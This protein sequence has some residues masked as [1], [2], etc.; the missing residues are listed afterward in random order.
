[1]KQTRYAALILAAFFIPTTLSAHYI[2]LEQ[3]GK[4]AQVYFGEIQ[5]GEREKSPGKLDKMEGVKLFR[6]TAKGE[7][8]EIPLQ[9]KSQYFAGNVAKNSLTIAVNDSV[10]V[11]DLTKYGIGVVKP[12]YYARHGVQNSATAFSPTLTLDIMP[13]AKEKNT[14]QLFFNK[15]PLAKVKVNVYAPNTWSKELR[16]DS[17]GKFRIET[18]WKGQYVLEVVYADK[19]TGEF[20]GKAYTAVRHRVTYTFV[21]K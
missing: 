1:M 3:K 18:P 21:K 14:F 4:T 9:K 11:Q 6:V 7:T 8:K 20:Q 2:W 5:E 17:E 12:M 10:E 15:E 19:I 16:S 13:V